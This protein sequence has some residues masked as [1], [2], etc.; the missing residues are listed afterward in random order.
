MNH[1]DKDKPNGDDSPLMK[2]EEIRGVLFEYMTRELGP[3]QSDVVREHIRKCPACQKEAAE[4]QM[5]VELLQRSSQEPFESPSRLSDKR[6]KRIWRAIMHPLLTW[7]YVHHV[8]VS[9]I[10]AAIALVTGMILVNKLPLPSWEPPQFG[11][12]I[13]IGRGDPDAQPGTTQDQPEPPS[14]E[15]PAP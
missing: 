13:T 1:S 7:I 3:G 10:V 4:I 2:C 5:T 9:L 15:V 12:T 8:L 14:P 11:P 6:R